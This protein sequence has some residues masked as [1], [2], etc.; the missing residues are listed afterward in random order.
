ML[1]AEETSHRVSKTHKRVKDKPNQGGK[2]FPA[3]KKKVLTLREVSALTAVQS[4]LPLDNP[5]NKTLPDFDKPK[6]TPKASIRM[7][8]VS[9]SGSCAVLMENSGDWSRMNHDTLETH[10]THA[11]R[12][13]KTG[14]HCNSNSNCD[15]SFCH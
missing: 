4:L 5:H 9:G 15:D 2:Q 6:H 10:E 7:A 13:R 1:Q 14:S 12:C 3:L 11:W 8:L